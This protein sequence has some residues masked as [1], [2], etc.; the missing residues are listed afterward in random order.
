MH[1]LAL[2]TK[3]AVTMNLRTFFALLVAVPLAACGQVADLDA[4]PQA[5]VGCE[6]PTE[7]QLNAGDTM[8][9]GRNCMSC[10]VSSAQAKDEPLGT[11]GTVYGARNTKT[12][13]TGG[14]DGV[15]VDLLDPAGNVVA[16]TKTNAAG[17]FYFPPTATNF[18]NV[19]A[20]V[21]K[22]SMTM[23]M[24]TPVDVSVG[25]ATCHWATGNAGDRIYIQ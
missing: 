11:G 3:G 15:T 20:R 16:S 1:A 5:K 21:T 23:K 9:P 17:N 14:V 8:L 18:K 22:G 19:S 25:C 2:H 13:N 24:T 6:T 12:C 10:H 4:V 7:A